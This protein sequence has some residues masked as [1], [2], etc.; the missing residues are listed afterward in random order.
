MYLDIM[1]DDYLGFSCSI[2]HRSTSLVWQPTV[3][4]RNWWICLRTQHFDWQH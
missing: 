1:L 3:F 4:C 2:V